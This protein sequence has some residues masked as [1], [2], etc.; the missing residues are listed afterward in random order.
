MLIP[1]ADALLVSGGTLLQVTAPGGEVV[2]A[3]F[4]G[5][6]VTAQPGGGESPPP[7]VV[8]QRPH[9]CSLPG[10]VISM[11][12][13]KRSRD[14]H[15]EAAEGPAFQHRRFLLQRRST[16]EDEVE[17]AVKALTSILEPI[18]IIVVGGIVGFV[19]IAMYMPLF[20][21]YDQIK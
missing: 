2:D 8:H 14:V 6:E 18:M 21:I 19:V 16:D 15:L 12:I 7:A 3:R 10:G 11:A 17:A 4:Q 9:V 20:K 5:E 1:L 13:E